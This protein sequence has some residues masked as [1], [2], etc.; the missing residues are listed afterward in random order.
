M[1]NAAGEGGIARRRKRGG[2]KRQEMKF[3]QG[4]RKREEFE[5]EEMAG[6]EEVQV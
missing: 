4:E 2:L 1:V 3:M 5:I 6:N